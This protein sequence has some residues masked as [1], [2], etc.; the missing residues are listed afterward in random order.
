MRTTGFKVGL[1]VAV[2][3]L[4]AAPAYAFRCGTRVITRGDPGDKV[5]EFCGSPISIQTRRAQRPYIDEF[6]RSHLGLIEEV[7]IEEW[8][9][10]LGPYQFMRLVRLENGLVAEIK[11]LG[12]GY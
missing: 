12:Y 8:T 9:Y 7:V 2:L 11:E 1:A 5:L 10:N 6:G 3:A 4:A